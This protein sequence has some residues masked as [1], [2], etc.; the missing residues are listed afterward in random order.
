[1]KEVTS[2]S[3]TLS[4]TA[5]QAFAIQYAKDI[6]VNPAGDIDIL[7]ADRIVFTPT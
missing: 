6:D 2:K 3:A 7:L 4:L 5:G 1:M